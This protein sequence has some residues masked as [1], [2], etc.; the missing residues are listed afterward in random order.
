MRGPRSSEK[1]NQTEPKATDVPMSRL[2][3]VVPSLK[4]S[5]L[6]VPGCSSRPALDGRGGLLHLRPRLRRLDARIR[7]HIRQVLGR[8][9]GRNYLAATTPA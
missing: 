4:L 8:R 5:F 3:R 6:V 9:L 1:P 7:P 2:L